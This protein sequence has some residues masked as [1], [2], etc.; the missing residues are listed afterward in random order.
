MWLI[1]ASKSLSNILWTIGNSLH[2]V[3]PWLYNRHFLIL[4]NCPS[5]KCIFSEDD[6]KYFFFSVGA[7]M[8]LDIYSRARQTVGTEHKAQLCAGKVIFPWGP[9]IEQARS[10][11]HRYSQILC[12][13][14][15]QYWSQPRVCSGPFMGG[16]WLDILIQFI[17]IALQRFKCYSGSSLH[18]NFWVGLFPRFFFSPLCELC[19]YSSKSLCD[20][21]KW[22]TVVCCQFE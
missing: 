8:C 21:I 4:L 6:L 16:S 2:Y 5:I 13:C 20:L 7:L 15:W 10:T 11:V 9:V 1:F 22:M 3:C 17:F 12:Y 18:W 14:F 19:A